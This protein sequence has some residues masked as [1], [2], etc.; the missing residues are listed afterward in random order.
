MSQSIRLWGATYSDV[1]SVL[2]PKSTSGTAKFTDTTPTTA[3]ASDVANGK[4]FFTSDGTQTTG[5]AS[6]GGGGNTLASTTTKV[7]S[8]NV[9]SI[10]FTVSGNPKAFMCMLDQQS[11]LGS[12]RYV[13]S[14][15]YDGTTVRGCWGYSSSN[16][17]YAYYSDSYF[18]KSHSGTTL[19][20]TTSSSSNGGYFRSNYTYR[21]IYVY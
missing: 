1:P 18:T 19:T 13:I 3:T 6:G 14:V 5:T 2:L 10:S 7:G 11:S 17:R 4:V 16:T 21:L 9:T 12:T 15:T 20:I 8:S